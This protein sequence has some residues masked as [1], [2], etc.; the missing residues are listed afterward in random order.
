MQGCLHVK[1]AVCVLIGWVNAF[2]WEMGVVIPF[3]E[4]AGEGCGE[5]EITWKHQ[6]KSGRVL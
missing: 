2:C 6:V 4:L 3:W 5:A 1:W